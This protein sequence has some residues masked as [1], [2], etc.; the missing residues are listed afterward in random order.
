[1][2]TNLWWRQRLRRRGFRQ[3]ILFFWFSPQHGRRAFW[4]R[5]NCK[6]NG[7]TIGDILWQRLFLDWRESDQPRTKRSV[8][9]HDLIIEVLSLAWIQRWKL[10]P[11]LF[12]P[13]EGLEIDSHGS[14]R[15][16]T[17]FRMTVLL[18]LIIRLRP[19][20]ADHNSAFKIRVRG[21]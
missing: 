13:N 10:T 20:I 12:Y 11:Q 2:K 6:C 1:M 16:K 9:F 14:M 5:D 21:N 3:V 8:E 4:L 18:N 15:Y 19:L 7:Q 17:Q